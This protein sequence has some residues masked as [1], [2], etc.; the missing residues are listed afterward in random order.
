MRDWGRVMVMSLVEV[1]YM[2][3]NLI[4]RLL[5]YSGSVRAGRKK[6][7]LSNGFSVL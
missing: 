6:N 7:I 1:I 4:N 3:V 2:N 5:I